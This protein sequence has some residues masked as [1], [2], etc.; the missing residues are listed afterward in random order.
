MPLTDAEEYELLTLEREQAMATKPKRQ[1]NTIAEASAAMRQANANQ[2]IAQRNVENI[3]PLVSL[4]RSAYNLSW[5][6][7]ALANKV[8]NKGSPVPE[9]TTSGGRLMQDMSAIANPLVGRAVG[10]G[11]EKVGQAVGAT[12][13]FIG[14]TYRKATN[15]IKLD[16]SLPSANKLQSAIDKLNINKVDVKGLQEASD[17]TTQSDISKVSEV[18]Q[19]DKNIFKKSL[20]DITTAFNQSKKDFNN[21]ISEKTGQVAKNVKQPVI[22]FF[23]NASK[24]YGETR[25]AI[26]N[27]IDDPIQAQSLLKKNA[28]PVTRTEFLDEANSVLKEFG[29]QPDI[30]N[31]KSYKGLVDLINKYSPEGADT[32]LVDASGKAIKQALPESLDIKQLIGDLKDYNKVFSSSFE[33]GSKALSPDEL[34]AARFNYN[35]G[36]IIKERI[37]KFAE[38]QKS[39]KP[40]IDNKKL[41]YTIFKP[42]NEVSSSSAQALFKRVASG[43]STQQDKDLLSFIQKGTKV[44]DK[45]V[46]GIGDF[47][48]ELN[49][50]A[51]DIAKSGKRFGLKSKALK[52]KNELDIQTLKEVSKTILEKNKLNKLSTI[53]DI[54][55]IDS[56]LSRLTDILRRRKD[57]DEIKKSFAQKAVVGA[58]GA[59]AGALI[60][61]INK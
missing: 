4:G 10:Y 59:G 56:R 38:L 37:P 54:R 12:S 55:K 58:F 39:Y 41:A 24:A 45:E 8:I 51:D 61:K 53:E 20:N 21:I 11:A 44:G 15:L 60:S 25:D 17:I 16:R 14:S 40:V 48:K 30:V 5:P 23:R 6:I 35:M 7:S 34:V 19:S 50:I 18:L 1:F 46:S 13:K 47:T 2:S 27:A 49:K 31:S 52:A 33:S 32:G 29:D 26:F 57:V 36:N 9:A 3:D 22:T 28:S 42:G 43:K